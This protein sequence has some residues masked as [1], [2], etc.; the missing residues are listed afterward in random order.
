VSD[1]WFNYCMEE[2]PGKWSRVRSRC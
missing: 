2:L 1:R